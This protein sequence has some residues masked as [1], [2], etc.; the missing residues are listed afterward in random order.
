MPSHSSRLALTLAT[1]LAA[2]ICT[3]LAGAGGTVVASNPTLSGVTDVSAVASYDCYQTFCATVD[4]PFTMSD[5]GYPSSE[6]TLV[7]DNA[8]GGSTYL[9]GQTYITCWAKNPAGFTSEGMSFTVRVTV[10]PPTF[11][12]VPATINAQATGPFGAVVTFFPRP[13]RM[14]EARRCL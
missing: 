10:P 6:L 8:L 5:P 1:W 4:F 7:C 11:Q 14:W 3:A 9:W 2:L 12:N 13:R